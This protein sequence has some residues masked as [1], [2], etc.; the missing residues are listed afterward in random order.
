MLR[1]MVVA[2]QR[3]CK[4]T[5]A[6]KE[7]PAIWK[8]PKVKIGRLFQQFE[9]LKDEQ[10]VYENAMADS[11]QGEH[12]VRTILDRL[13]FQQQDLKKPVAVLSGGERMRLGCEA[14]GRF[15]QSAASG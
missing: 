13:L 15:Q 6:A 9:N 7:N 5:I 14:D 12:V 3:H 2:K 11:V 10:S 4:I 8:A 1:K